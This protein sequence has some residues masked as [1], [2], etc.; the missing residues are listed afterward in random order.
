MQIDMRLIMST[1]PRRENPQIFQEYLL[2][3]LGPSQAQVVASWTHNTHYNCYT[4]PMKLSVLPGRG[5]FM[6]Y[7]S[8]KLGPVAHPSAG[9]H[10]LPSGM[11]QHILN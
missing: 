3:H 1:P 2:Q 10:P 9:N 8:R 7:V 6:I 11:M 5:D 4:G